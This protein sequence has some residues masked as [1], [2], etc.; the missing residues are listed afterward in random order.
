MAARQNTFRVLM[1]H[2]GWSGEQR[3]WSASFQQVSR[4]RW[5]FAPGGNRPTLPIS[6]RQRVTG[7]KDVRGYLV[8]GGVSPHY[9][10]L[11]GSGGVITPMRSDRQVAIIRHLVS[12][13]SE[14]EHTRAKHQNTDRDGEE[15][16]L[17]PFQAV[18]QPS[19]VETLAQKTGQTVA[20]SPESEDGPL[21]GRHHR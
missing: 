12:S 17:S 4:R 14:W 18:K 3:L 5:R 20:T 8:R 13:R 6:S 1:G 7:D 2:F 10:R 19:L 9:R 16:P 21:R 11:V 15:A